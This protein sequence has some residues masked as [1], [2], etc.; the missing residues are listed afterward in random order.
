M[1]STL[2][3]FS[4]AIYSLAIYNPYTDGYSRR[5]RSGGGAGP[6]HAHVL[7]YAHAHA[8]RPNLSAMIT[9]SAWPT[10]DYIVAIK[11]LLLRSAAL[12]CLIECF[13]SWEAR[14]GEKNKI[15]GKL[16]VPQ[17]QHISKSSWLA[18][19]LSAEG[20]TKCN[21]CS[22]MAAPML[23]QCACPTRLAIVAYGMC[24]LYIATVWLPVS[25]K[26]PL[27]TIL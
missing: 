4:V 10:G 8:L 11:L 9:S 15:N 17:V 21:P 22:A 1:Q 24:R 19:L 14:A 26:Q 7:L 16:S 12:H 20:Y 5:L 2:A 13:P 27:Y 3:K 18:T 6:R 25:L 23:Y